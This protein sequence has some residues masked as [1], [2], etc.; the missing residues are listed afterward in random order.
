MLI[1]PGGQLMPAQ[2][3]QMCFQSSVPIECDLLFDKPGGN[4]DDMLNVQRPDVRR[5]HSSLQ[6][7]A[8]A[9]RARYGQCD[10]ASLPLLSGASGNCDS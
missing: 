8:L 10:M 3:L 4:G 7:P 1:R 5:P 9:V 6:R 2:T